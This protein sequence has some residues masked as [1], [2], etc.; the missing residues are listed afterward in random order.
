MYAVPLDSNTRWT[1]T[2]EGCSNCARKRAS[3]TKLLRP[4]SNVFWCCSERSTMVLTSWRN[5]NSAGRY[6]LSATRPMQRV[7][8][9]EIDDREIR[10]R[11]GR[12]RSRTRK[13][14]CPWRVRWHCRNVADP[15]IGEESS[16]IEPLGPVHTMEAR[17][18]RAC[19]YRT[20]PRAVQSA[21]DERRGSRQIAPWSL[22]RR[23]PEQ[24]R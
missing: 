15:R 7:V 16:C 8:E 10:P 18:P 22:Q 13:G 14:A 19:D 24:E 3:C 2:S 9:R 12:A 20:H 17:T 11:P 23:G 21:I 6:S 4:A 1:L 5:A